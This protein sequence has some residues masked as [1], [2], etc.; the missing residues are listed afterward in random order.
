MWYSQVLPMASFNLNV[1]YC[2][3]ESLLLALCYLALGL[4]DATLNQQRLSDYGLLLV[5]VILT[6]I[7]LNILALILTISAIAR[8]A[9]LKKYRE[10]FQS[11]KV[12]IGQLEKDKE[13][14]DL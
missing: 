12:K 5:F 3:N 1:Q 11:K 14:V 6:L 9:I 13:S 4:S 10:K 7:A 2:V 8:K